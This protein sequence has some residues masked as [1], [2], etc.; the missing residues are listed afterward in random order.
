SNMLLASL[1]PQ[2]RKSAEQALISFSNQNDSLV[3]LLAFVLD[4]R[5]DKGARLAGAALFKNTIKRRWFEVRIRLLF[6]VDL[7]LRRDGNLT[8]GRRTTHPSEC[9]GTCPFV[10]R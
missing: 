10:A 2:T 6:V 9:K 8:G 7:P 1:N 3:A 5:Q 4:S